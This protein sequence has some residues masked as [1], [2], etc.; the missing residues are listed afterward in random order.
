[1]PSHP[2]SHSVDPVAE[3]LYWAIG[4]AIRPAIRPSYELSSNSYAELS[5][6]P[7]AQGSIGLHWAIGT[8]KPP[9]RTLSAIPLTNAEP[10]RRCGV[11]RGGGCVGGVSRVSDIERAYR[12]AIG[13]RMT[14]KTDTIYYS[15][16]RLV[17]LSPYLPISLYWTWVMSIVGKVGRELSPPSPNHSVT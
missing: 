5:T 10:S 8:A 9:P 1:M 14:R 2:L 17:S 6:I 16:N 12:T 3:E 15:L 7:W 4:W 13:T 11:Y